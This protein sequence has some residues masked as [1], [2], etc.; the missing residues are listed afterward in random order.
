MAEF[1]KFMNSYNQAQFSIVEEALEAGVSYDF[2][3]TF[4]QLFA[5]GFISDGAFNTAGSGHIDLNGAI[6]C[7]IEINYIGQ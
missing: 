4:D 2:E 1:L 6:G 7:T 3:L 5:D